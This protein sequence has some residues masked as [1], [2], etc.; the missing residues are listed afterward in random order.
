MKFDNNKI[1]SIFTIDSLIFY[2]W[3]QNFDFL[4]KTDQFWANIIYVRE[5]LL[6]KSLQKTCFY[7]HEKLQRNPSV[8]SCLKF[9]IF[10]PYGFD[11]LGILTNARRG[12]MRSKTQW[13]IYRDLD[14]WPGPQKVQFREITGYPEVVGLILALLRQSNVFLINLMK[15][16]IVK[17]LWCPVIRINLWSETV[18][19]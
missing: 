13:V 8:G 5:F 6:A 9:F 4:G 15:F 12:A 11:Y 2:V 14:W 19:V 3:Y 1:W 10:S 17:N 16:L 7:L 18:G